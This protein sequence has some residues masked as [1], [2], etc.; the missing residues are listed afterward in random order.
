M[1]QNRQIFQ[2]MI[3]FFILGVAMIC[4][5][6]LPS[7][8]LAQCG[9]YLPDS[10]C[11]TCHLKESPIYMQGEWHVI[12][13]GKDCCTQCHGG[14]CTTQD[15][16]LAHVGVMANPLD[17][18]YVNCYHCHPYDYTE[19]AERFAV[20]LG[21]TPGS[22]P[23]ATPISFVNYVQPPVLIRPASAPPPWLMALGGLGFVF[24]LV[25]GLGMLYDR[26]RTQG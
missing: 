4:W 2:L 14:N 18:I 22:S 5:A 9:D 23:T 21:V 15:K 10:S 6:M 19:R 20:A 13:F 7:A 26:L 11:I 1:L 3:G 25:L 8:A 16:D 17:D 12:H 24:L